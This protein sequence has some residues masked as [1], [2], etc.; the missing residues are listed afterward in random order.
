MV[1]IGRLV[2]RLWGGACRLRGRKG[3]GVGDAFD[4]FDGGWKD[5]CHDGCRGVGRY[6]CRGVVDVRS[7]YT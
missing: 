2:S 7:C 4:A 1:Q 5:D 6:D 3:D